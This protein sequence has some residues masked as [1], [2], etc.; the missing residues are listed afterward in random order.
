[1]KLQIQGLE[2]FFIIVGCVCVHMHTYIICHVCGDQEDNLQ[3]SILPFHFAYSRLAGPQASGQVSALC[4]FV[5]GVV[6][7]QRTMDK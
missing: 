5:T 2:I 7:V 1:M 4:S 3:E 6:I